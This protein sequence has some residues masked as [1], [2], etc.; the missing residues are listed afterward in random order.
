MTHYFA[1]GANL[2]V[3]TMTKRC[4]G[5]RVLGP[6]RL[7]RHRFIIMEPG[8]ATVVR[9]SAAMVHGLLWTLSLSDIPALDRYEDVHVG[10]YRKAIQPVLREKAGA[11][12]AMLYVGGAPRPA[13]PH[14]GY[15]ENIVASAHFWDM[16]ESYIRHLESFLHRK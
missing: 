2:D 16:P 10:L 3:A 7:A 8:F 4:P 13:P 9:D 11:I 12:G 6:A 14:P 1:Y 5:A 15:V